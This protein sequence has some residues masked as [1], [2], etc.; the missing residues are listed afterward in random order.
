MDLCSC[1]CRF[2][3]KLPLWGTH[4]Q[5]ERRMKPNCSETTAFSGR[6]FQKPSSPPFLPER[7]MSPKEMG[8]FLPFQIVPREGQPT[9]LTSFLRAT[10]PG[11]LSFLTTF[12]PILG[13]ALLALVLWI[14]KALFVSHLSALYY[15][16]SFGHQNGFWQPGKSKSQCGKASDILGAG[17]C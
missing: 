3:S 1:V 13:T 16:A 7:T 2:W 12:W 5:G 10:H 6:I 17:T 14:M 8:S 11:R 15:M 4:T 9:P